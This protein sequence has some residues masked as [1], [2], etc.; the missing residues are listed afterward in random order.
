MAFETNILPDLEE[1]IRS[2][3][4]GND[5]VEPSFSQ[6]GLDLQGLYSAAGELADVT[7]EAAGLM[8]RES[9][10]SLLGRID[11]ISSRSLHELKHNEERIS[12]SLAFIEKIAEDLTVLRHRNQL[13]EKTGKKLRVIGVNI[14]VESIRTDESHAMFA[15][16]VEDM[17]R[18]VDNV[19]DV[20]TAISSNAKG[21]ASEQSSAYR[22]ISSGAHELNKLTRTGEQAVRTAAGHLEQVM[23]ASARAL[24]QTSGH[25]QVIK[26]L[27]G[28]IVVA[29]QVRDITRQQ[30]EHAVEALQELHDA[31]SKGMAEGGNDAMEKEVYGRAHSILRIQAAQLA[32]VIAA[33]DSAHS[34]MNVSFGQIGDE[35]R[36]MTGNSEIIR[37][38]LDRGA[39]VT[40]DVDQLRSNLEHLGHLVEKGRKLNAQT[41]DTATK[42]SGV[43][44]T[45]SNH[46][47]EVSEISLDMNLQA[48]NAIIKSV[49]LGDHGRT[50]QVLSHEVT[51]LSDQSSRFVSE[52]LGVLERVNSSATELEQTS[53]SDG[54][55]DTDGQVTDDT[56]AGGLGH[57]DQL[58]GRFQEMSTGAVQRSEL[59]T[60]AIE[61]TQASL[62][63]LPELIQLLSADLERMNGLVAALEPW[64]QP[65]S[66]EEGHLREFADRYTMASE[67]DVH[68]QVF[69]QARGAGVTETEEPVLSEVSQGGDDSD[70]LDD[71]IELF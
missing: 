35:V 67:R 50:L 16:F 21:A 48:L 20:A 46:M 44:S 11:Q 34:T 5:G 38:G 65:V 3:K 32:Q 23:E 62:G 27:V 24:E 66:G 30:T 41:R 70:G 12:Q 6:I 8:G 36:A 7:V 22:S 19:L 37:S 2:V 47:E 13:L 61:E 26:R 25:S 1:L 14:R 29:V 45:F 31:L 18:L 52:V 33:L 28:E 49:R 51:V 53:R 57:F 54:D 39:A 15:A 42:A 10:D 60:R 64:G 69:N 58:C 59:L 9:E 17:D 56:L 63:F 4:A 55:G 68:D 40:D 71:N 43:S